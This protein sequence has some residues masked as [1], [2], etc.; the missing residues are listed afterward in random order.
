[1]NKKEKIE[2]K[3][4][5]DELKESQNSLRAQLKET[6][7]EN[8]LEA[9]ETLDKQIKENAIEIIKLENELEAGQSQNSKE[10]KGNQKQMKKLY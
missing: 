4:K 1:M 8:G 7:I 6:P 10:E 5:L 2:L 9:F 3:L